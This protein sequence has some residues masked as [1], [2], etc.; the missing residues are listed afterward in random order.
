[1]RFGNQ[2]AAPVGE[3]VA[4]AQ[5]VSQI[6]ER[7]KVAY[8]GPHPLIPPAPYRVGGR[9]QTA[10]R[11]GPRQPRG[12]FEA[13]QGWGGGRRERRRPLSHGASTI[14]AWTSVLPKDNRRSSPVRRRNGGPAVPSPAL[15]PQRQVCAGLP[16]SSRR[17]RASASPPVRGLRAGRTP[18]IPAAALR[19]GR[20][21]CSRAARA[22]EECQGWAFHCHCV[23]ATANGAFGLLCPTHP[24]DSDSDDQKRVETTTIA[25]M[26][27]AP[28]RAIN[29][30]SRGGWPSS[31]S[32]NG[33]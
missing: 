17:L 18:C 25:K 23:R 13:L 8:A 2:R 22:A 3:Q 19:A 7:C 33:G 20:L 5:I 11:L 27:P 9:S 26:A 14:E 31:G 12:F 4:E 30:M 1:M 15:Q 21:R 16:G 6:Q 29:A 32:G 24:Y 10:G 28:I